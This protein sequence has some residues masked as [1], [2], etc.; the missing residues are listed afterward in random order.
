V[1]VLKQCLCI[2]PQMLFFPNWLSV[3]LPS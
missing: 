2:I 3:T 1:T